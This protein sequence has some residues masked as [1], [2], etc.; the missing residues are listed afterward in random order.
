MIAATLQPMRNPQPTAPR[1]AGG[2]GEPT[3]ATRRM[4]PAA[5]GAPSDASFAAITAALQSL[6]PVL[7]PAPSPLLA[8]DAL[9]VDTTA[10]ARAR[11]LADM[12]RQDVQHRTS[13]PPRIAGANVPREQI[14]A[15]H[16]AD[17]AK[18]Q[19][20]RDSASQTRTT[21]PSRAR[22]EAVPQPTPTPPPNARNRSTA[23]P[24]PA[25]P[26]DGG[27]SPGRSPGHAPRPS[28]SST[29][30]APST[31]QQP[32]APAT[33]T[34]PAKPNAVPQPVS[35][36]NPGGG[37]SGTNAPAAT[38]TGPQPA[39]SPTAPPR[40]PRA[41]VNGSDHGSTR[42]AGFIPRGP[43]ESSQQAAFDRITKLV[44]A[45]VSGNRTVARIEL[46]PPALGHLRVHVTLA[47]DKVQL[48][49]VAENAEGRRVLVAQADDLRSAIERQG[50]RVQ[51]MDFPVPQQSDEHPA[52]SRADRSADHSTPHPETTDTGNERENAHGDPSA[53]APDPTGALE[54]PVDH[55]RP[56]GA[57]ELSQLG[58]DTKLDVRI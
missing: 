25:S 48:R 26:R 9:P 20:A 36:P 30:R 39:I 35:N 14:A 7:P 6:T 33:T 57:D 13:G 5:R 27:A 4:N 21:D 53:D 47:G 31:G 38:R 23:Q 16:R 42:A 28:A 11:R 52:S 50:V 2:S 41:P 19:A 43:R 29:H 3:R 1:T 37:A 55:A 40:T 58:V 45:G 51:R 49:L 34:T 17:R 8:T 54:P 24:Y 32:P 22:K 12:G 46:N 18:L 56:D 10:D 44:R 15:E